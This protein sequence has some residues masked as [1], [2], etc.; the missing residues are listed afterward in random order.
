MNNAVYG[1]AMEKLRNRIDVKLVNNKKLYMKWTSEP[2][3]MSQKIFDNNLVAKRK[4]KVTLTLNKPAYVRMCILDLNKA[5]MYEFHCDYIKNKY[6][7]NSK[8]FFTDTDSLMHEIKAEDISE[9]FSK[10]KD[11][12]DFSN[13]FAES[14]YYDDSNKLVDGKMEDETGG[15]AIKRFIGMK[16][17]M[18]SFLVYDSIEHKKAKSV[19]KNIFATI[20][21]SKYKDVLL[22]QK[23][24]RHL[25]NRI[26]NKDHRIGNYE[27]NKLSLSCFDDKIFLI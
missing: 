15:V 8:L 14:K 1:T 26:Q 13:Y 10:V 20:S 21:H 4:S 2:R 6:D 3:Y 22:N 25:M 12:F 18:C 19:N 16:P 9:D 11:M 23:C 17:K 27:I 5:L 24:L 7:N